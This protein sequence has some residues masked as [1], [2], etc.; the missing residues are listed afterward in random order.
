[1]QPH[2]DKIMKWGLDFCIKH[3]DKDYAQF[4]QYATAALCRK[5]PSPL[6]TGHYKTWAASII[7]AL[8]SIN[9]LFDKNT[10]PYMSFSDLS[11]KFE[12][13]KTTISSKSKHIRTILNMSQLETTWCFP[14]IWEQNSFTWMIMVNGFIADA[15][16]LDP[17][18][19]E[20]AFKKGLIP[21]VPAH[22]PSK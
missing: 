10:Q 11:E 12:V 18:I 22:K 15:R 9:F 4:F 20:I 17:E 16:T 21:Y 3:L 14:S 8:G 19:Q 2:Y 1:M 13:A 7:H 5:R 6:Q